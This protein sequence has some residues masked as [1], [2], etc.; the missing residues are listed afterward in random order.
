MLDRP[1][2]PICKVRVHWECL[3]NASACEIFNSHLQ[4]N[5]N[6][7]PMVGVD[8]ESEWTIFLTSMKVWPQGGCYLSCL[9]S[10]SRMVDTEG[11]G[12]S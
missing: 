2:A 8:N 10:V 9:Y 1:G 4:E 5:F 11:E 7:L 12:S 6:S 3:V